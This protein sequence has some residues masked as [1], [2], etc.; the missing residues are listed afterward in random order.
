MVHDS[1]IQCI[2]NTP[3]VS[4]RR[5][6]QD[7]QIDVIAKLE[8]LNPGG[9]VKDRP[10][11]FIIE[12]GLQDGTITPDTHLIE[13]T[14]GNLG[15]ALA[16]VARLYNLQFTCVVDPK[17]LSTNFRILKQLGASVEM[18]DKPDNQGGF[19]QTRIQRVHEILRATPHGLWINQYA[20]QLNW[21]AHYYGTGKEIIEALDKPID[22]IAIS[23]STTGTI[24]GL[25]RCLR[26]EWPHL[27]VI[28]VD[29]VGSVIFGGLSGPRNIPGIGAS[30]VPELLSPSEIDQVIYVDDQG[31]IQGCRNLLL[32]EGILA[33]GSS[34]SI[35]TAI[36]KVSATFPRPYRILTILPDRGERYLD[37][38]YND[39]WIE[40]HLNQ[41][42]VFAG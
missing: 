31:A 10:A 23:V 26:E 32:E 14:S 39:Q 42:N 38:I 4:L 3:L 35:I 21:Q 7:P 12:Q 6:F 33:G 13:S 27:Q 19:L 40:P 36:Q 37:T 18:V 24:L 34:G 17:I 20:N 11:R 22:C 16:M 28:A 25:A 1:V 29:A 41:P 5:L 15:I 30:R 8:F 2:G 9:S